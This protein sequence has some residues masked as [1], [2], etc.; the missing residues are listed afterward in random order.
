MKMGSQGGV[1]KKDTDGRRPYR[2]KILSDRSA[3]PI[4]V[5]S[6]TV[7]DQFVH[8]PEPRRRHRVGEIAAHG[9]HDVVGFER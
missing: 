1:A 9:H 5:V 2:K 8:V 3:A 7:L 4:C 6:K